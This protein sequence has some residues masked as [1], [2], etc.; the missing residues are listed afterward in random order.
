MPGRAR[1]VARF[2]PECAVLFGRLAR[3]PRLPRRHRAALAA[4]VAYLAMPIDLI[5]D[6]IPV[7][8]LLDDALL[9][10]LVLRA[11]LR[12]AGPEAVREH[13]PGPEGS[14]RALLS[15][16]GAPPELPPGAVR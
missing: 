5:P 6:P 11:V 7:I 9:V 13:W 8:G 12:R 3:D 10:A 1:A 14:L 4:L 2:V 16:A 15:A